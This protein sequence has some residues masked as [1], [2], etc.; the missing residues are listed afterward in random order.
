MMDAPSELAHRNLKQ[1]RFLL[2][3]RKMVIPT[4]TPG[5]VGSIPPSNALV[6]PFFIPYLAKN[7][8][9]GYSVRFLVIESNSVGNQKQAI[10]GSNPT[11]ASY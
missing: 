11:W 5:C 3:R 8:T 10:V 6:R 7:L 2:S 4:T 1:F 9:G